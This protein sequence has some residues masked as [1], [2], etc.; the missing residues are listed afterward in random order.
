MNKSILNTRIMLVEDE[1]FMRML[2]IQA[3]ESLGFDSIIEAEDGEHALQML[4]NQEIDLLITDIEMQ[5]M[6]GLDLVKSIRSGESTQP[7]GTPVIFLSGLGD[8]STLAAA[9]ELDVNGFL[10]KPVSAN[11]L[12]DKIDEALKNKVRLREPNVYK[13]MLFTTGAL[14][15]R[16]QDQ[17]PGS[18]YRITTTAKRVATKPTP[19]TEP[20]PQPSTEPPAREQAGVMVGLNELQPGMVLCH[21]VLANGVAMLRKGVV[22]AP[23]HILVLK[24]MRGVL[25]SIEFE[26]LIPGEG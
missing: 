11:Q 13:S 22:L 26:V 9:S 23:G 19:T 12:R 2:A 8:M 3:L 7:R 15:A 25:A 24:N 1:N 17:V 18:G 6:S 21:D 4:A 16:E 10:V 14:E 20:R 5:P